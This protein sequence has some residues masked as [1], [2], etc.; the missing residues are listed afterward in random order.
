MRARGVAAPYASPVPPRCAATVYEV[1][2]PAAGGKRKKR[3]DRYRSVLRREAATMRSCLD[4][5]RSAEGPGGSATQSPGLRSADEAALGR[6]FDTIGSCS[7]F[8]DGF[9]RRSQSYRRNVERSVQAA[10]SPE[11]S[12]RP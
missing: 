5:S 11:R 9:K 12:H 8:V 6:S 2:R 10:L 4:R 1:S 7:R 3:T